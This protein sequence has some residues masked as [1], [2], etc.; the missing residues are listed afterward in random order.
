MPDRPMTRAEVLATLA[1]LHDRPERHLTDNERQA[2]A[3]MIGRLQ[4]CEECE[5]NFARRRR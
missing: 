1:Q 4:V 5:R 3:E 2:V